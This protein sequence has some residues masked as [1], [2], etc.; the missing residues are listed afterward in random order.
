MSNERE[1]L[2]VECR[3]GGETVLYWLTIGEDSGDAE[4]CPACIAELRLAVQ[5]ALARGEPLV[6]AWDPPGSL[7]AGIL[8]DE[9]VVDGDEAVSY[10]IDDS[11]PITL[12]AED[13]DVDVIVV[14]G[15]GGG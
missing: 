15:R 10:A 1:P 12:E 3:H 6:F 5:L 13:G 8:E 9:R 2:S 4:Y 7:V 14:N 11:T